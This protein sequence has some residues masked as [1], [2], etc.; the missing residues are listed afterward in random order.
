M[1]SGFKIIQ[2]IA[3]QSEAAKEIDI[4]VIV[5]DIGHNR[6]DLGVWGYDG[7][8][9]GRLPGLPL[10]HMVLAEQKLAVEIG[11]IDGVQIDD[12]DL[13]KAG[14]RK[15]LEEFA[16]GVTCADHKHGGVGNALRG[17]RAVHDIQIVKLGQHCW[18]SASPAAARTA[19]DRAKRKTLSTSGDKGGRGALQQGSVHGGATTQKSFCAFIEAGAAGSA[20]GDRAAR[21]AL[22]A[23][24]RICGRSRRSSVGRDAQCG[25]TMSS[26]QYPIPKPP[27]AAPDPDKRNSYVG[28]N[29]FDTP[30]QQSKHTQHP[31]QRLP[32]ATPPSPPPPLPILPPAPN[33]SN[34]A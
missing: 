14:Y 3:Y 9:F 22:N 24:R 16:A 31:P 34:S 26:A 15:V 32:S 28:G 6:S 27:T 30:T 19:M 2:R 12:S 4:K 29:W 18:H 23:T 25:E 7:H 17:L 21:V 20:G 5:L 13:A 33:A 10:T 8:G 11:N 1:A